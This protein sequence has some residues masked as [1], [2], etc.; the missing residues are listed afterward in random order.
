[1]AYIIGVDIGTTGT[2]A[3]AFSE[4]AEVLATA[5]ASY[6]AITV[7]EDQ[8]ELEPEDLLQAVIQTLSSVIRQTENKP[9]LSGI[10]FS[11]AMHSLI[12]MN[13]EGEPITR[14]ITW[15]DLRSQEQAKALRRTAEG[16][17][18]YEHCGTP[19]YAMTPLCKIIW[20]KEKKPGIFGNASKYISIKEFVWLRL[21][22]KYQIDF[23]LASA[24]AMF[25]IRTFEWY[26][27]ALAIAGIRTEQL[28]E[29]LSPYHTEKELL[30]TYRDLLQIHT[31]VPFLIGASDGCLAN[32][33]SKAVLPGRISITIGTSGAM[34]LAS[35]KPR[36]DASQRIFNYILTPSIYISG[37]PI[38]NGG[39]AVK[40]YIDEFMNSGNDPADISELITQVGSIPPGSDGLLFLPYLLGERAPVWDAGARAVFLGIQASHTK[41]HFLRA[42]LEGIC[43]SLFQIGKILRETVGPID[44]IYASGGFVQ[45]PIW[46]QM[47]ADIFDLPVHVTNTA[48]ASAIGAAMLGLHGFGIVSSLEETENMIEMEESFQPDPETHKRYQSYFAIFDGL[49]DRLKDD[50]LR[51]NN[52]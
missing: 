48:D 49:Y 12:V 10:S 2:K 37:G 33:G 19:I 29:P 24:T 41:Q 6:T 27:P 21:F 26:L 42:V 36:P 1:M 45:S 38:N 16:Q 7:E 11:C 23:S 3:V 8:H 5:Y 9:G 40:W 20:L 31:P 17:D 50:F 15:A 34:R 43:F 22:G 44:E 4:K 51:L 46:L 30:A 28:S 32:L 47:M 52:I 18:I 35:Q 13:A 14:A 25:D 39:N